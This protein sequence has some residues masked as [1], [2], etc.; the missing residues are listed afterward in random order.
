MTIH[1]DLNFTDIANHQAELRREASQVRLSRRA[2][3][4]RGL[5]QRLTQRNA[6]TAAT[7]ASTSTNA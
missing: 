4:R 3:A 7:T 6:D 5:L 2:R 1:A